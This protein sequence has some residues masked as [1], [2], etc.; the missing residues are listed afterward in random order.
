M[1]VFPL[2]LIVFYNK[3]SVLENK[4]LNFEI[5]ENAFGSYIRK[6]KTQKNVFGVAIPETSKIVETRFVARFKFFFGG[7]LGWGGDVVSKMYED[8][9]DQT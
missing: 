7:V 5:S 9:N 1:V 2:S 6:Q 8:I 3:G 4:F